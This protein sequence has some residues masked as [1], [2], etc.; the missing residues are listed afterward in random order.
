MDAGDC[1]RIN[2]KKKK[3][4][5]SNMSSFK[6]KGGRNTPTQWTR[7]RGDPYFGT[8]PRKTV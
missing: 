7:R 6:G 8:M 5:K 3:K 4:I 2:R 1:S